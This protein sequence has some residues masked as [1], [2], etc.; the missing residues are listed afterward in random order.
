[1]KRIL[2]D[3]THETI[4]LAVYNITTTATRLT[5]LP[6]TDRCKNHGDEHVMYLLDRIQA[7]EAFT[8]TRLRGN[9]S[10]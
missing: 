5:D 3:A 9:F 2:C 7:D 10:R 8:V 1:M 4:T 6:D